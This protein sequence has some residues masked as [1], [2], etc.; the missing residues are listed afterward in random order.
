MALASLLHSLYFIMSVVWTSSNKS[1]ALKRWTKLRGTVV[2]QE[3]AWDSHMDFVGKKAEV[4][5]A[6]DLL[7]YIQRRRGEKEGKYQS[8]PLLLWRGIKDQLLEDST[9]KNRKGEHVIGM[10]ATA[11]DAT[12]GLFKAFIVDEIARETCITTLPATWIFIEFY[13]E[14]CSAHST[15]RVSFYDFRE[16]SPEEQSVLIQYTLRT[17]NQ[18]Y[19]EAMRHYYRK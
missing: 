17:N 11:V 15:D 10:C 7:M 1:H 8:S 19:N 16:C 3:S 12:K 18:T 5:T 13:P 14:C 6:T 9:G 4:A 2:N